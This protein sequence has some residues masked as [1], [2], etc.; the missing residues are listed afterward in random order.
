MSVK[1]GV[2]VAAKVMKM[3]SLLFWECLACERARKRGRCGAGLHFR[4]GLSCTRVNTS[5]I[6]SQSQTIRAR[7]HRPGPHLHLA[8][9]RSRVEV[10]DKLAAIE[11]RLDEFGRH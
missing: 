11:G 10:V 1:V 4:S 7:T 6:S 3:S 8:L 5:R 9:R 2:V